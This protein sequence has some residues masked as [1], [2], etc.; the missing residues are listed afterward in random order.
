MRLPD[1]VSGVL[2]SMFSMLLFSITAS[3]MEAGNIGRPA[4]SLNI[5]HFN[6]GIGA[7]A[8]V[9]TT[10][11]IVVHVHPASPAQ[12]QP[13]PNAT[14]SPSLYEPLHTNPILNRPGQ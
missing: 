2:A 5:A 10:S 12:I 14:K 6:P 13:F 3:R 9:R 11:P 4:V 1:A 8:R 7:Q